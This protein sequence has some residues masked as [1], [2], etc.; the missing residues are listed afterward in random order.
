VVT[1]SEGIP[2]QEN[3][4]GL[5]AG[6]LEA[7]LVPEAVVE[8]SLAESELV[9]STISTHSKPHAR[10]R[11]ECRAEANVLGLDGS[12]AATLVPRKTT[13]EDDRAV[14]ESR[15]A[16]RYS[17]HYPVVLGEEGDGGQQGKEVAAKCG[18]ATEEE[19]KDG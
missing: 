17:P 5:R 10:S 8:V 3:F 12:E 11:L 13:G 1:R 14:S 7:G 9:A 16:T 19:N 15:P 2:S 18:D 4:S 6:S